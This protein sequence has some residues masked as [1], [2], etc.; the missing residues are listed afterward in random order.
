VHPYPDLSVSGSFG[1]AVL[2]PDVRCPNSEK[3]ITLADLA[4]YKSKSLGKNQ[5]HCKIYE[6]R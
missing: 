1:V 5:V 6:D 3:L 2:N 4:L